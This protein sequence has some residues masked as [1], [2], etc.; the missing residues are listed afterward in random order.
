MKQKRR[1]VGF[2]IV[3]VIL[4]VLYSNIVSSLKNSNQETVIIKPFKKTEAVYTAQLDKLL[5][6]TFTSEQLKN[7]A[8][9]L[10]SPSLNYS[11]DF[12]E[13]DNYLSASTIKVPVALY[14]YDLS[15]KD[16]AILEQSITYLAADYEDG[17]GSI[18][19]ASYGSSYQVKTLLEKMIMESDNVAFN[20]LTRVYFENQANLEKELKPYFGKADYAHQK[21][22]SQ[23]KMKVLKYLYKNQT[24]YKTLMQDLK[25]NYSKERIPKYL[26]VEVA[27]KV[28][29]YE[30]VYIDYGI[31]YH[32]KPYLISITF[33]NIG[34]SD[35]I[36]AKLAQ[37][38]DKIMII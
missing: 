27:N 1:S 34:Y 33:N 21:S 35:E 22:N 30:N 10:Y 12:N 32:T 9:S 24:E 5:E 3:V 17:S 18:Q 25:N 14:I 31:V 28:G 16:S 15:K 37:E 29:T 23:N 13:K 20:M 2:I 36:M 26:D 4:V 38:I 6:D 8:V 7:V 19:F 11:Y